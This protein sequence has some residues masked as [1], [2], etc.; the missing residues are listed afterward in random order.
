M[1]DLRVILLKD[2]ATR[3]AHSIGLKT[4]D[5]ALRRK[6]FNNV[7]LSGQDPGEKPTKE[8]H[9]FVRNERR[10]IFGF[11]VTSDHWPEFYQQAFNIRHDYPEAKIIAGG[12]AFERK[13]LRTADGRA[14]RDS[15][16]VALQGRVVDAAVFGGADPFVQLITEHGGEPEGTN[17]PGLYYL[18]NEKVVGHGRGRQPKLDSI[19]Y[20]FKPETNYAGVMLDNACNNNCGF[21]CA[22][23]GD[24]GFSQELIIKTLNEIYGRYNKTKP[25]TLQIFDSNPFRRVNRSRLLAI[26][27]QFDEQRS[28]VRKMVYL[29]PATLTTPGAFDLLLRLVE[30]GF[31]S[32]FIG[33]DTVSEDVA[34][35]IGVNYKNKAKT[36]K[37]LDE[38]QRAIDELI[39][40]LEKMK[41]WNYR[42]FSVTV[43]F[44]MTP[45]ETKDSFSALLSRMEKIQHAQT[46]KVT[47]GIKFHALAPY[48]DTT[49]RHRYID[50]IREPDDPFISLAKNAW[51]H[52]IGPAARVLDLFDDFRIYSMYDR[53]GVDFFRR[54]RTEVVDPL[55]G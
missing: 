22:N 45:F 39:G 43:A 26:F 16:T 41:L 50:L 46:D 53:Y 15:I 49:V 24:L 27:D 29:D 4:I 47:T 8:V 25:A 36:Q 21:C 33:Q 13:H 11:Y 6:S 17:L 31:V 51:K 28:D 23:Q 40:N 7:L 52:E 38:E 1:N 48:P 2:D 12:P 34:A 18:N 14:V 3:A 10:T 42:P 55:F 20:L 44:I 30:H 9:S 35:K 37:Q 5:S 54:F 32:F 19:P